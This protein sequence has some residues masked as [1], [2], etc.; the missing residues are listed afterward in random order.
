MSRILLIEDDPLIIDP[1]LRALERTSYE[2]V[3]AEDGL[4][5]LNL[6]LHEDFDLVLRDIML[7][8]MEGWDVCREIRP[9]SIVPII[10]LT[11]LGKEVDRI[12]S[13]EYGQP[14]QAQS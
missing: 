5:G 11:A 6:V 2:V 3:N 1:T 8:E 7:P 4:T 10:M 14:I 9:K 12:L 13:L